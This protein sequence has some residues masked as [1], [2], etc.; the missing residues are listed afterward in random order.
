MS[1]I[2]YNEFIEASTQIIIYGKLW[3]TETLIIEGID[4]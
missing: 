2:Y 4:L 3:K 1:H